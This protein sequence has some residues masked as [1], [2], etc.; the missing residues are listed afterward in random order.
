[1]PLPEFTQIYLFIGACLALVSIPGP[2]V[3]FIVVRGVSEG[4]K[5]ALRTAAGIAAGN[6]CQALAA[7]FGL[8]ALLI[9]YPSVYLWIKY[10]GASYLIY[11]GLR[12]FF[13]KANSR[14]SIDDK[15]NSP[16]FRQGVLVG[17]LNPKVALFLLAFLP[18]FTNSENGELWLQ[19][20]YLGFGFVFIGWLGDSTWALF[21]G[22]AR[23]RLHRNNDLSWGRFAAGIVYCAVG[24]TTAIWSG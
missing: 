8:A 12:S 17:L 22:L 19:L 3:A 9:S 15:R 11:L 2:A 6:L 16:S 24:I 23:A 14:A 10:A 4:T 1:M 5:A 18:Q 21:A 13:A 20:L 7:A